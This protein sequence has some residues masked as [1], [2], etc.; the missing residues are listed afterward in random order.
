TMPGGPALMHM[1]SASYSDVDATSR[2]ASFLIRAHGIEH[3]VLLA[4][5]HCGYYR[6]RYPADRPE[7]VRA[8][9]LEDLREAGRV[10]TRMGPSL[11]VRLYFVQPEGT[12]LEFHPLAPR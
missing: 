4:H 2:A 9:Q 10:V 7:Q 3:V 6:A 12:K 5:E 11:S 1:R 8:R